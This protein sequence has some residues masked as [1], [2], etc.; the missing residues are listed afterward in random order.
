MGWG[1]GGSGTWKYGMVLMVRGER[2]ENV[3]RCPLCKLGLSRGGLAGSAHLQGCPTNLGGHPWVGQ[4]KISF[5]AL[6]WS[7]QSRSL[8]DQSGVLLAP[9]SSAQ[10][11]TRLMVSTEASQAGEA[12]GLS[13]EAAFC[14]CFLHAV[15]KVPGRTSWTFDQRVCRGTSHMEHTFSP[16]VLQR[17]VR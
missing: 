8:W 3:V 17:P 11:D 15:P 6:W 1:R 10:W 5:M 14:P 2:G 4:G 7:N 12:L 9:H 13:L 16:V